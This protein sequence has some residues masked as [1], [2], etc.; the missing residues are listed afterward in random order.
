MQGL[1]DRTF[2]STRLAATNGGQPLGAEWRITR[3]IPADSRRGRLLSAMADGAQ[4][5]IFQWN[6]AMAV[7]LPLPSSPASADTQ[8]EETA[9]T[10]EKAKAQAEAEP[11]EEAKPLSN[12]GDF[13]S[14]FASL[15]D[16]KLKAAGIRKE[17]T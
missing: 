14:R 13:T 15:L 11:R 9:D 7:C 2:P 12:T 10:D 6:G 5:A 17:H 4:D 8:E 16:D 1:I 3:E